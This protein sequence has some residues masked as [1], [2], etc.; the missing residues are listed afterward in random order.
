MTERT[1]NRRLQII[2]SLEE[3]LSL[4][5]PGCQ[6]HMFGSSSS[7]LAFEGESDLDICLEIPALISKK[8]T[9]IRI[10]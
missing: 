9:K 5:F 2:S 7:G 10:P 1:S 4:E 6:L 3:W 8:S